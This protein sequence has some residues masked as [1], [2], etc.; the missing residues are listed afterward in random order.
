ME[1]Y[2]ADQKRRRH[3]AAYVI[4]NRISPEAFR[5]ES[6]CLVWDDIDTNMD[7]VYA[8][9]KEWSL[10]IAKAVSVAE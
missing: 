5:G 4:L 6:A 2:I 7:F 1:G 10:G 3:L 9:F 8:Y